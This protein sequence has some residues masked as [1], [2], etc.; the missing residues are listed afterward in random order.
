MDLKLNFVSKTE[1]P[2]P[3]PGLSKKKSKGSSRV[4]YGCHNETPRVSLVVRC[5][6]SGLPKNVLMFKDRSTDL[7][8]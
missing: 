4:H 6:I 1:S 3:Y 2:R 7:K 8:D 5:S